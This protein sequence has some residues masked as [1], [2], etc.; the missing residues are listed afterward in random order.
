MKF[1]EPSAPSR[2]WLLDVVEAGY[3]FSHN[4]SAK[5][6]KLVELPLCFMPGWFLRSQLLEPMCLGS[7]GSVDSAYLAMEKGWAI[8]LSG[9]FH[10][11]R[12]DGG[13]GFC[14]YPDITMVTH[15][16]RRV[17][18]I[19]KIMIVDLDAH[20]GNGH[21][22]DHL[23]DENTYILDAYNHSIY[24]GDEL[25]KSAIKKDVYVATDTE[26]FLAD[27]STALDEAIAEF[28]PEFLVY[29]A[30][31]D[32]LEMDPLG[33]CHISPEG[34]IQRDSIVFE[35][36]LQQGIPVTMLMSGGYQQ[37][38]AEIIADSISALIQK[39]DLLNYK[40]G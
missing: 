24:P 17:Y 9:G 11:A 39:F 3:L 15:Y 4:F 5:V 29:N 36:C 27:V 25:A 2:R 20:Q 32:I 12:K 13:E 7:V 28:Q 34:I 14:V 22:R 19:K 30:G 26:T 33:R 38:N 1:H 23:G 35:K 10:H 8:N 37:S 40:K 18:N 6:S 31:T 21:E 16:L